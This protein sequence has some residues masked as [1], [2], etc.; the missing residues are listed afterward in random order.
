MTVEWAMPFE[1]AKLARISS[2]V[3]GGRASPMMRPATSIISDQLEIAEILL[4]H[5]AEALV[6]KLR[7]VM[8]GD[9]DADFGMR[10]HRCAGAASRRILRQTARS[11]GA[12]QPAIVGTGAGSSSVSRIAAR[13]SSG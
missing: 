6:E 3:V 9:E 2:C 4:Q 1:V 8:D 10:R 7:P 5:R 13:S 12:K 11:G